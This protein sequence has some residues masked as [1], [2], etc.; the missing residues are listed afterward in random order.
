[1]DVA[2][3]A[4]YLE[5]LKELVV[6]EEDRWI[7]ADKVAKEVELLV[8]KASSDWRAANALSNKR[9]PSGIGAPS[10]MYYLRITCC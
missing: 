8:E 3:L 2:T 4:A 10:G 1:M 7:F 9:A 5:Y 6:Y